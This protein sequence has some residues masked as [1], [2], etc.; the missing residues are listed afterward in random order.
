MV[1]LPR[2]P[3]LRTVR[4]RLRRIGALI[5]LMMLGTT[6]ISTGMPPAEATNFSGV[7]GGT[8]CTAN[9]MQ[10]NDDMT[11]FRSSLTTRMFNAVANTLLNDVIPTDIDLQPEHSSATENTDVVY[12][13]L[14]YSTTCGFDWHP[15]DPGDP[16]TNF[17]IGMA[18]CAQLSGSSRCQRFHVRF[19]TSFTDTIGNDF[20]RTLACHETG[21]TLGLL[22]R[23]STGCMPATVPAN[24]HFYNAHDIDHVNDNYT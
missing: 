6:A 12:F 22:H 21:H 10:D 3:R 23:N 24:A 19:D 17:V 9:N 18:Q 13:D 5:A 8:S 16:D 11:Y 1:R 14:D 4:S 15:D 20:A 7:T 2:S